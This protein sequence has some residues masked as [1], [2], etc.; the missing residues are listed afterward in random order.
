MMLS[1]FLFACDPSVT[2]KDLKNG[3][4]E[5]TAF[6]PAGDSIEGVQIHVL[7]DKP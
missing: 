3:T 6:F 5:V 1:S 4:V 7:K 2:V